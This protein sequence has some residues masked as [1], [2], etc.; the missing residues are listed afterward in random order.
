M[1]CTRHQQR[2]KVYRSFNSLHARLVR[3]K[4]TLAGVTMFEPIELTKRMKQVLS[5]APETTKAVSARRM[6]AMGLITIIDSWR[7]R[8]GLGGCKRDAE[9]IYFKINVTKSTAK[10]AGMSQI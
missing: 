9:V 2:V 3:V 7:L 8:P 5:E 1:P 6:E 10:N 4:A